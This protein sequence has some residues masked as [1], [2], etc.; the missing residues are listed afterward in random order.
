MSWYEIVET[1]IQDAISAGKFDNLP[2]SG[3][4]LPDRP[5]DRLAGANWA[6][7]KILRDAGALP[8]WLMLAR[9][10]EDAERELAA[11]EARYAARVELAASSGDWAAHGKAIRQL[12]E[13]IASK[14]RALRLKQDQFNYDAPSMLLERPGIWVDRRLAALRAHL[15]RAGAP[16][17]LLG[18]A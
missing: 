9:D 13:T 11:L 4:P 5:E 12:A 8:P 16:A 6:G 7:N 17:D 3:Q 15:E 2:G 1:R 18:V 14:A 10:I